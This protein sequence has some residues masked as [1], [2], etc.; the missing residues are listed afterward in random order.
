MRQHNVLP[1]ADKVQVPPGQLAL[2][3]APG[4]GLSYTHI[5]TVLPV[6]LEYAE[7]GSYVHVR[8]KRGKDEKQKEKERRRR[9]GA[10][11]YRAGAV[12]GMAPHEGSGNYWHPPVKRGRVHGFSADSRYRMLSLLNA[13]PEGL[14]LPLI[15]TLT[16]PEHW[17]SDPEAWKKN[18]EAFRS[19]LER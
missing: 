12:S 17:P 1:C 8:F 10:G 5:S 4:L 16:Y 18:L 14:P 3:G 13:L 9:L 15:I 19:A 11:E 7:T 6:C 2:F